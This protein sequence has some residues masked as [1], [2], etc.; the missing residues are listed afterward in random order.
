TTRIYRCV[1]CQHTWREYWVRRQTPGTFITGDRISEEIPEER[2]VFEGKVKAEVLK[3]VVDVVSTL[4]DEAKFNV[5]NDSITVKA[6]DPAHVA[7]VDLTLDRGAFETYKADEG[8]LCVDMDKL[9][10]IL[11]SATAG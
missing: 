10:E 5:G 6:V 2:G 3:E 11:R 9:K 4:V 1:K 7:L 8:E